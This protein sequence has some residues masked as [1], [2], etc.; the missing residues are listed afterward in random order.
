MLKMNEADISA[1]KRLLPNRTQ[2]RRKNARKRREV[3]MNEG[4]LTFP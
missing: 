1:L 2:E 4:A 3:S